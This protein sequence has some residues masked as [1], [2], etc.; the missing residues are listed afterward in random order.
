MVVTI[1]FL[2][3]TW[4]NLFVRFTFPFPIVPFSL[5]I[6]YLVNILFVEIVP[7]II[8]LPVNEIIGILVV[9]SSI[10]ML[11]NDDLRSSDDYQRIEFV[12][13]LLP[14][15]RGKYFRRF[16]TVYFFSLSRRQACSVCWCGGFLN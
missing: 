13:L 3:L 8:A 16:L 6:F 14:L 4:R 10:C 9:I 11:Y 1:F 2:L 12:A 7:V 5:F 15:T